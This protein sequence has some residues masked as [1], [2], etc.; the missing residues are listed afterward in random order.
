MISDQIYSLDLSYL[1]SLSIDEIDQNINEF[2]F[3]AN[4]RILKLLALKAQNSNNFEEALSEDA[5]LIPDRSLLKKRIENINDKFIEIQSNSPKEHENTLPEHEPFE[6]NEAITTNTAEIT[7]TLEQKEENPISE[8]PDFSEDDRA[9]GIS[10]QENS[11]QNDPDNGS[12]NKME[13][14]HPDQQINKINFPEEDLSEFAKWLKN[15]SNNNAD[16]SLSKPAVEITEMDTKT[17]NL[18]VE[19]ESAIK[20]NEWAGLQEKILSQYQTDLSNSEPKSKKKAK[21]NTQNKKK[22]EKDDLD[23]TTFITETYALLLEK[24]QK[25]Q[26]ALKIYDKLSLLFPEKRHYFAQKIEL[27]KNL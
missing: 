24:Q 22:K 13:V 8:L 3:S 23:E 6:I 4:L 25:Y 5:I 27:L 12:I 20:E 15:R 9:S 7:T 1:Q 21:N 11:Q 26:K 19:T 10:N 16:T 2:P 17:T 18:I 14:M